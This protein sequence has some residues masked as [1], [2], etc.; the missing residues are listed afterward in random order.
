LVDGLWQ[1]LQFALLPPHCLLCGQRGDD[2]R[3]LCR[4]CAADL[5]LNRCCCARCALPLATPAALC[6]ECL[7]SEPPFDA[8]FAPYLYAHPLDLLMTKLK[9]GRNLAAGRVLA[10]LW[11]VS[12]REALRAGSRTSLPDAIVPVPLHVARLGERGYNQALELAKPLAREFGIALL[13][14][15]LRRTRA[16]A[17]QANLDAVSRRRNL[18]SAFEVDMTLLSATAAMHTVVLDDVMTTG[19]TLRE[20]ARA[21]K[22][23]GMRRVEVWA[24][25]RAPQRR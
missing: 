23:A 3:D 9:F 10:E 18:R 13:P 25:A 7:R 5:A 17:A 21:L 8:A 15:L 20:C 6:G 14:G 2:T 24:L 11:T 16:T 12:L 22:R 19:T 4:A 1:R